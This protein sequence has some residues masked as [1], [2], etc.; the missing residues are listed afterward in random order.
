M[1]LTIFVRH[2]EWFATPFF[3]CKAL[4]SGHRFPMRSKLLNPDTSPT[5]TSMTICILVPENGAQKPTGALQQWRDNLMRKP[6]GNT[7]MYNEVCV[8]VTVRLIELDYRKHPENYSYKPEGIRR[9]CDRIRHTQSSNLWVYV[10]ACAKAVALGSTLA[11][12][13]EQAMQSDVATMRSIHKRPFRVG[14]RR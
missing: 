2:L 12:W 11:Q 3:M 6:L 14:G 10:I 8:R 5:H 9:L 13:R 7:T 4:H 1:R